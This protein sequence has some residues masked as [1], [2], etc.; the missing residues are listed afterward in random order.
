MELRE[1]ATI[2]GKGGLF[3]IVKPTRAGVI[4]ES[5]DEQKSRIVAGTQHRVSLLKE[6]S[7][8]TTGKESSIPLEEVL[9]SISEKYGKDIPASSKS[10][11]DELSDF[12]ESVVPNYDKERV[13]TS[14][15]KKL[16]SWYI[17]LATHAP[18]LFEKKTADTQVE[19]KK[20]TE[21][22]TE[23]PAEAR[24]E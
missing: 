6:I 5:L 17:I 15:I 20:A 21:S 16:V 18:E 13:Y 3:K 10:S 11:S 1:V 12:I 14:D 22:T 2:S 23:K 9:L 7:I 19:D 4:L 8:Y 24:K